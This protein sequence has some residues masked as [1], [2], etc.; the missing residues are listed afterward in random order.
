MHTDPDRTTPPETTTTEAGS[1]VAGRLSTGKKLLFALVI[2]VLLLAGAEAVCRL[3][4]LGRE[5]PVAHYIS[6]WHNSP[7]GRTFWVVRAKGYNRD[8]MRDREHAVDKPPGTHRIV[9]LGDSVTVGYKLPRSGSYPFMLEAFLTQ[10]GLPVEVFNIASLGWSTRQEATAYREIARRYHPDHVFLGF[11]LN[12]VPE[13]HN[14]LTT[15]PPPTVSFLMRHSAL[16]RWAVSAESRQVHSV[17]ELFHRP[18]S[19]AVQNGWKHVLSELEFLRRETQKDDCD[20]SVVIF[21]FRFQLEGN[22]P[23]SIAQRTLFNF[24]RSREIPCLDLLPALRKVGPAAFLDESHL[25]RAGARVV[26]E[27]LIRWGRS[28]CV[29]CG[30]DLRDIRTDKC[31]RCGYPS[32]P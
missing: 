4:G 30:Y 32:S 12:D 28:G 13:M 2:T 14:N 19:P 9:C 23:P 5:E 8:G 11:C 21:P 15:P 6:D 10:I 25:S 27:E 26:A 18:D 1:G 22:A 20:L 24:C 3:A 17:E 7:D 31:P 16:L 29:M